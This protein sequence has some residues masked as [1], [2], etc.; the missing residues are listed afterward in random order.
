MT[1]P[2]LVQSVT[3]AFDFLRLVAQSEEGL[4]LQQ[5]SQETDLKLPTVHNLTRPLV[6]LG[7]LEKSERPKRYRIGPSFLELADQY[8][9]NTTLLRATEAVKTLSAKLDNAI[10]SFAEYRGGDVVVLMRVV[11]Q[12]PQVVQRPKS[13]VLSPYTSASALVFQAYWEQHTL[14]D[15]RQQYPFEEFGVSAWI[16][17]P[18]LAS[19][20]QL[21]HSANTKKSLVCWAPTSMA[22]RK[23]TINSVRR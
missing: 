3:R 18:R 12:M 21:P 2:K 9:Q 6:A 17:V 14:L 16:T 22:S 10:I 23:S 15:F 5:L 20:W 13:L 8:W 7:I 4:T 19:A 11:P 1:K